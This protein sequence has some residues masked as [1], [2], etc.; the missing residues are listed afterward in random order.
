MHRLGNYFPKEY[1]QKNEC[2]TL[3]IDKLLTYSRN[4]I[5]RAT[6][7]FN[8]EFGWTAWDCVNTAYALGAENFNKAQKVIRCFVLSELRMAYWN[9][10]ELDRFKALHIS[11]DIL[12]T[13]CRELKPKAAFRDVI[14]PKTGEIY[15]RSRCKECIRE[16]KREMESK[17]KYKLKAKARYERWKQRQKN[18]A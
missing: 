9:K 7:D 8:K 13:K 4:L 17:E 14:N 2:P 3:D 6:E 18:Q 5:S 11:Q 12:C 16:Y 1:H 15:T 10:N